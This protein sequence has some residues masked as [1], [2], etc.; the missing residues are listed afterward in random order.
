MTNN[1]LEITE[2]EIVPNELGLE[3]EAKTSL[4]VAFSGFFEEARKWK[5]KSELIT[6][7]KDARAARLEIK[8]LRVSAEKTRKKLKE[9]SLRMGKAIDGANN[10]LLAVIVPIENAL[11]EIEKAEERA[12][13]ARIQSLNEFRLA[14]LEKINHVSLGVNLGSLTDE[15]WDAY[16]QQAKDANQ[17]R[18]ERVAREAAEA[19]EKLRLEE[20]AREEQ[21][22]E[23]LR[24]K[25]E[26]EARQKE[27][28]EARKIAAQKEAEAQKEKLKAEAKAKAE[29]D[30]R[31]RAENEARELREAEIKRQAEIEAKAKAD[32]LAAKESARKAAAAPDKQKL[33]DFAQVIRSL[34]LPTVKSEDGKKTLL[35]IS[36]KV[37]SF[38]KWIETQ[39]N[40]I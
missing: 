2:F 38:A 3:P 22:L 14:E 24:L 9:D 18:L 4:E 31:Q 5:E 36:D 35:E 39:A 8:N 40:K 37:E 27:L 26:A 34:E 33:I 10:I 17:A 7:P 13:A 25:A 6:S 30:A 28:D 12:E 21:R 23:N 32:E 15:Q 19:A 20:L 29:S 16:F 11:E 1:T